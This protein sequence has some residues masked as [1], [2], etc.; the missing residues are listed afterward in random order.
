MKDFL[1]FAVWGLFLAFVVAFF[2]S[3]FAVLL[4]SSAVALAV[5]VVSICALFVLSFICGD[6]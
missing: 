4:G 6:L 5:F 3:L 1:C 2:V